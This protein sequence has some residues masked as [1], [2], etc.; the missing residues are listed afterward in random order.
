[1]LDLVA[2]EE[3]AGARARGFD[4]RGKRRRHRA[5]AALALNRLDDDRGG[6][7]GHRA[8]ER[9]DVAC[10]DEADAGDERLELL[11]IVRIP[12]DRERAERP[13]AEG[14]IECDEL[15]ALRRALR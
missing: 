9:G 1:A 6:A 10:R 5:D 11:A 15:R 12:G 8:I 4:R 7:I 13:A 14:V 3:R 2:D